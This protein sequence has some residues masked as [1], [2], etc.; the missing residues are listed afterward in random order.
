EI[1]LLNNCITDELIA[2][3]EH[4]KLLIYNDEYYKEYEIVVTTLPIMNISYEDNEENNTNIQIKDKDVYGELYLFDNE[5]IIETIENL[6]FHVRGGTTVEYPKKGFKLSLKDSDGNSVNKNLL[7][8]RND[9]DWIL[10]AGYNDQERI[11]NVFSSRIWYDC[12]SFDNQ[13][14]I[15]AGM[16]YKY[17]ELFMNG[18]YYGLYA[19]GFPIDEKQ[20]NIKDDEY[21]FKKWDYYVEIEDNYDTTYIINRYKVKSSDPNNNSTSIINNYYE[22]LN[23]T[24]SKE[25]L[26]NMADINN[27]IDFYLFNIFIQNVD[28]VNDLTSKNMY[29]VIKNNKALYI[30]WDMDQSFGNIWFEVVEKNVE[31]SNFIAI[32]GHPVDDNSSE[33]NMNSIGKLKQ[34]DSTGIINM[35]IDKY[36]ILKKE[37]FNKKVLDSILDEY[38]NNIF[39]S[40]A[41]NRDINKWPESTH[42]DKY[43]SLDT[44]RKYVD[45]RLYYMDKY[46][47]EI[48]N[49]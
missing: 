32:Y 9:D 46:M 18:K 37:Y 16:Y 13:F 1:V 2:K 19:L 44:F 17:V 22:R 12:C 42:N 4:I 34:L 20:L 11:R 5:S 45:D 43:N 30:P 31:K 26:Y 38:E 36:S 3:N 40:G 24:N 48:S 49:N 6:K 21:I 23:T 33:Y 8:M 47:D 15:N 25:E 35:I 29:L 28:G 7:N 41:F 27:L 10:Y 39:M 14:G